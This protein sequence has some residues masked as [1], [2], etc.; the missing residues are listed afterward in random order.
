MN[1]AHLD[2][3]LSICIPAYNGQRYLENVLSAL[4]PQAAE[5]A[6]Q[7]EV[8]VV[9]D[10]SSDATGQVVA[11]ASGTGP[12]RYIRNDTNLGMARNIVNCLTVHATGQYVW[13]WSQH[14]LL[15][16]GALSRVIGALESHP[17]LDAMYVNFRCATYPEDWP[18]H[19]RGGYSGPYKHVCSDQLEQ[20]L[21][22]RWEE[23][24]QV[25]TALCTQTYAHILRRSLAVDYWRGRTVGSQFGRAADTYQ[26]TCT[27]AETMFGKPCLY[28]GDPVFT[29]YNGAQTWG[30]LKDRAPVFLQALPEL[31]SIYRRLGWSSEQVREAER[32]SSAKAGD[33][34]LELLR[35]PDCDQRR[36]IVRFLCKHWKQEGAWRSAWRALWESDCCALL[37]LAKRAAQLAHRCRLWLANCRPVRW[38]RSLQSK[39]VSPA[40]AGPMPRT[41]S[42]ERQGLGTITNDS[43]LGR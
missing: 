24:L 23:L 35:D 12:L 42:G 25:K 36:R 41:A 27:V 17:Q 26:Q 7:V 20:R 5:H 28:I 31:L 1:P 8:L 10:C 2:P 30:A 21:V 43:D 33:V 16:F 3:L 32:F 34:I 6:R 29:I 19:V 13:V 14:C 40:V 15:A 37:R 22:P 38:A 4:L 18:E 9:D 39:H 11:A